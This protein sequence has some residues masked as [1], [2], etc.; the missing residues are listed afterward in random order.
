[1][2]IRAGNNGVYTNMV[3]GQTG[4][5][6]SEPTET[7]AKF[8]TYSAQ[9]SY[10]GRIHG[11][12]LRRLV[13]QT[14]TLRWRRGLKALRIMLVPR[15]SPKGTFNVDEEFGLGSSTNGTTLYQFYVRAANG[16][17]F[18]GCLFRACK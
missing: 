3:L 15:L 7:S 14:R 1:M 4:Y 8:G 11:A 13:V 12:D 9:F 2:I 17:V 10:A 6:P 16:T 5:N 18:Q